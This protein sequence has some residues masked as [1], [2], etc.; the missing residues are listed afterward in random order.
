MRAGPHGAGFENGG[1]KSQT[2]KCRQP[3]EGE[4]DPHLTASEEVGTSVLQ[5]HRTE[6]VNDLGGGSIPKASTKEQSP[7]NT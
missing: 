7:A 1:R 2:K 3:L 5:L 4:K 6:F